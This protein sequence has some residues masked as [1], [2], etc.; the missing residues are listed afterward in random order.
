MTAPG[1]ICASL[2]F[3]AVADRGQR[4]QKGQWRRMDNR[5]VE[6]AIEQPYEDPPPKEQ[7]FWNAS[8][9]T[10][11]AVLAAIFIIVIIVAFVVF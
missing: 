11:V 2:M 3:V 6:P 4:N 8:I 1:T 9:Y 7:R 10:T 5:E